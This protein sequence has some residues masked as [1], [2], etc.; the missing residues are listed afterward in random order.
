ML[1]GTAKGFELAF[2]P[3]LDA[4]K[5]ETSRNRLPGEVGWSRA[6]R[7]KKI[8]PLKFDL[9]LKSEILQPFS[10]SGCR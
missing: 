2:A 1:V 5:E 9:V 3:T 7:K 10:I 4:P 6:Q 8:V